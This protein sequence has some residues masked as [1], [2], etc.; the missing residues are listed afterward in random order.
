MALW[1]ISM[2]AALLPAIKMTTEITA[3]ACKCKRIRNLYIMTIKIYKEG[4]ACIWQTEFSR[5]NNKNHTGNETT[6]KGG[7]SPL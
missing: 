3:S 4:G 6:H 1:F 5:V 2:R 7:G